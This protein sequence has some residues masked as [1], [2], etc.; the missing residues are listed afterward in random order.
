ML[1]SRRTG[2]CSVAILTKSVPIIL[3]NFK[4][5]TAVLCTCNIELLFC[6][7]HLRNAYHNFRLIVYQLQC[8]IANSCTWHQLSGQYAV[9]LTNRS[10]MWM[11]R[12]D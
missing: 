12:S 7:R 8:R 9:Q 2:I 10:L 6:I 1:P 4:L 3:Y 11:S 5:H